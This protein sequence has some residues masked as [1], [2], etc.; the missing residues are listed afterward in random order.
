[1]ARRAEAEEAASEKEGVA[2]GIDFGTT[3]SAVAVQRDDG[4]FVVVQPPG[5]PAGRPMM[6]SVV[7]FNAAGKVLVGADALK[8]KPD[9]KRQVLFRSVKRLMGRTYED[10]YATGIDPIA[11]GADPAGTRHEMV[12]LLLPGKLG[13]IWPE[14]VAAEIIKALVKCAEAYLGKRVTRAVM[15]MPARFTPFQTA[16]IERAAQLS[17]LETVR[18]VREPELAVRAYGYKLRPAMRPSDYKFS[19][20]EAPTANMFQTGDVEEAQNKD[21]N[22]G[23]PEMRHT[24]VADLGGG[25]F[26]VCIVR[27]VIAWD[28][29]TMLFTAGDERL[30]GDDFDDDITDWIIN[31]MK[32][33]LKRTVGAWPVRKA[34]RLQLKAMARQAK[35]KL[36]SV[37][38]VDLTWKGETVTLSRGD[39]NVIVRKTLERLLM[40]IREASYGAKVRLP[41]ETLAVQTFDEGDRNQRKRKLRKNFNPDAS[42][43][44]I[45]V[46]RRKIGAPTTDARP[47]EPLVDEVLCI[48]AA[49]WTPAV[50]ELLHLISGVEPTV[51]VVDPEKAVAVGGAILGSIMDAKTEDVQVYSNWRHEWVQ[52]L[53]KRPDLLDRVRQEN[54]AKE[55]DIDA[56]GAPA[57]EAEPLREEM[58]SGASA[59]GASGGGA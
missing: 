25:T 59:G 40:P 48:G 3:N 7:A 9:G 58:V 42:G 41:F 16:A 55:K 15:G 35:E 23:L 29:I 52:H 39:F 57:E 5:M 37:E 4:R 51:S 13:V 54:S 53:L 27:N 22:D 21:E 43:M 8:I 12:R 26:D 46:L 30:G 36:S 31:G 32:P 34:E 11:F 19:K 2:I 45:E 33:R 14:M 38:S 20:S 44:D 24:L 10:A 56:A 18:L 47:Q 50:R 28:E 6:P 49:S 17:G 1:M